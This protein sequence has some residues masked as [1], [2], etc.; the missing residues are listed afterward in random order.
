M[1]KNG[2]GIYSRSEFAHLLRHGSAGCAQHEALRIYV[3]A[4]KSLT[5]ERE[6]VARLSA[7]LLAIVDPVLDRT[8][9]GGT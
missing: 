2:D 4:L 9:G 3:R 1:A 8:D 6:K 7:A 5:A